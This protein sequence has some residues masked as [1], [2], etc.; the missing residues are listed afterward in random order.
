VSLSGREYVLFAF[1]NHFVHIWLRRLRCSASCG[2]IRG[3]D[4]SY[5]LDACW[6]SLLCNQIQKSSTQTLLTGAYDATRRIRGR[7]CNVKRHGTSD[8][9]R[10]HRIRRRK[11]LAKRRKEHKTWPPT[12]IFKRRELSSQRRRYI[13]LVVLK[14]NRMVAILSLCDPSC[15]FSRL[16]IITPKMG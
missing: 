11:G 3:V 15:S 14:S 2:L 9:R 1:A 7:G 10:M 6:I 8:R 13:R 12:A 16:I 5:M 4:L